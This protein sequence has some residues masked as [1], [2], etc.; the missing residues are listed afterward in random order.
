MPPAGNFKEKLKWKKNPT[1]EN[2]HAIHTP[3]VDWSRITEWDWPYSE[4]GYSDPEALWSSLYTKYNC[5]PFA[6]Q[7]PYMWHADVCEIARASHNK[8]DFESALQKRRDERFKEIRS[9]WEKTRSQLTAN[10]IIWKAPARGPDRPWATFVRVGRHFSFDT[11]V[12]YFGNFVVD[13]PD[14]LYD[15]EL[16]AGNQQSTSETLAT[17]AVEARAS[18]S[19]LP[20]QLPQV[21]RAASNSTPPCPSASAAPPPPPPAAAAAAPS[22]KTRR[23]RTVRASKRPSRR[24]RVEKSPPKQPT[25]K[26]QPH[27]GV[28]RS[29][30]LQERVE[31]ASR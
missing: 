5:I 12:G 8:N 30:R 6:I 3:C 24:S 28:R 19:T 15:E 21:P 10:P 9:H 11:M 25:G 16:E 13:D 2:H 4:L 29:A 17:A 26:A 27:E 31:R 20:E 22:T 14:A 7:D 23:A 1:P 18:S